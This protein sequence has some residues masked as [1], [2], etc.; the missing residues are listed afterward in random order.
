MNIKR[1]LPRTV[2]GKYNSII[3]VAFVS[4]IAAVVGSSYSQKKEIAI[5]NAR[6]HLKAQLQQVQGRIDERGSTAVSMARLVGGDPIVQKMVAEH[7]RKGLSDFILKRYKENRAKDGM[8]QLQFHIPPATSLFRAHKPEKFNDDLSSFRFGVVEVNRSQREVYGVEKGVAGFGIRGIVPIKYQGKHVGSVEFGA[9][10]NDNFAKFFKENAGHELSIVVPDGNGF[11]YLA[12]T[13]NLIIPEKS[14]PWLRKVMQ[15]TEIKYKLVNKN[16]KNLLTIFSPLKNY[17]D[18]TVGIIAIPF[19]LTETLNKVNKELQIMLAVSVV[20]LILLILTVTISF[21]R[22]IGKPIRKIIEKLKYAGKG[23]LTQEITGNMPLMKCSE[24]LHCG[25]EQ[26]SCF[27]KETR[28]WETAGSF[29]AKVECPKIITGEYNSC[30]ECTEVYQLT[31]IDEIQELSSYFNGFV[32]SMRVLIGDMGHSVEQM[33]DASGSMS[34]TASSMQQSIETASQNANQVA[35]AAETMSADMN[36]VAAA[37]E[38]ATTNVNIVSTATEN[39]SEQFSIISRD[40]EKAS[41]ITTA[42]VTQAKSAQEKVDVLGRSAAEISKVT[43]AISDISEQ[44]NLLALNATIEAARAG[45]AGKGF[46]VV[47]NEIKDLAKQ[48][49]NSTQEIKSKIEDIQDST[50][51]TIKEIKE[52]SEVID[53]VNEI[54]SGIAGSIEEQA[55]ITNEIGN[56]VIQAAQGIGEV[57]EHVAISSTMSNEIAENITEVSKV[58]EDIAINATDVKSQAEGLTS[59]ASKIDATLSTFKL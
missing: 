41:S 57:N 24:L 40:T 13:H 9:K 38:E 36:S 1:L 39:M 15:S 33:S 48:T 11:R 19:E 55:E 42:A 23:D 43:E 22:M 47:A 4:L 35:G 56:N 34:T 2:K 8:A 37:S 45:E 44:T 10:L 18:K 29:S 50:G 53:Q 32:Y 26:C 3:F 12:K 7:N 54:V 28:C 58:T 17:S 30:T 21:N 6:N 25:N 46:A 51:A 31:R 16:G 20:V 5:S 14:Y 49:S 52:I 59:L 27:N